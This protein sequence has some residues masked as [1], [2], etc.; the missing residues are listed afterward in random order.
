MAL[1]QVTIAVPAPVVYSERL[2]SAS[3][4]TKSDTNSQNNIIKKCD[5]SGTI[6][7]IEPE[8]I[9][10]VSSTSQEDDIAVLQEDIA[11]FQE[12][13]QVTRNSTSFKFGKR[14]KIYTTFKYD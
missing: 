10:S 13:K 4:V 11:G 1:E 2:G 5:L 6:K 9:S 12:C 8:D 14:R 7:I 3:R